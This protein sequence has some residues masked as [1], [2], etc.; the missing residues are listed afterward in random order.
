MVA[1]W[2]VSDELWEQ[3]EP[4]LPVRPA[5]KTGPKPL[6]AR[7]VLQ[8]ILF[9]LFT[10]TVVGK[11][12]RRSCE[13]RVRDDLQAAVTGLA[14]R[15]G[16]RP[17]ARGAAGVTPCGRAAR[18]GVGCA[19]ASHIRGARTHRAKPGR[20]GQNRLQAPPDVIGP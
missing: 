16:L 5:G 11:T 13:V 8:G 1:P 6:D 14:G 7:R 4:L 3:I 2:V 18:L 19:D 9:V 12:C 17:A 10:G 15:R 20:P